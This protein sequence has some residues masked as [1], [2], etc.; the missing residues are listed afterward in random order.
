MG[1]PELSENLKKKKKNLSELGWER[2]PQALES[3]AKLVTSSPAPLPVVLLRVFKQPSAEL[4][5][6]SCHGHVKSGGTVSYQ[7]LFARHRRVWLGW[8][9][10]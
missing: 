10:C 3:L 2:W 9:R 4:Q 6:S 1:T 8:E 5:L 7:G